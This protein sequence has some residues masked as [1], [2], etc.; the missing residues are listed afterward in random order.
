MRLTK[1]IKSIF[2]IN[3]RALDGA[4]CL[5]SFKLPWV[6]THGNLKSE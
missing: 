5:S 4:A 3:A 1:N 6:L 2:Y